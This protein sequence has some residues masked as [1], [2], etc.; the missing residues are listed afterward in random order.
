MVALEEVIVFTPVATPAY[1]LLY[2][3]TLPVTA[4]GIV[5]LPADVVAAV[6]LEQ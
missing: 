6:V 3:P 4:V 2:F 5:I 1:A